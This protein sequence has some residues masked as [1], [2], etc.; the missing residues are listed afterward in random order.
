MS[1]FETADRD[2]EILLFE[3]VAD[4]AFSAMEQMMSNGKTSD[5]SH[6]AVQQILTAGIKLYARKI[7]EDS[8]YFMPIIKQHGVTATE[9]AIITTEL[10]FAVDLNLFDLSMWASRPRSDEE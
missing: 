9:A 2:E 7:D 10:L 5:L 3:K 8:S 6:L 1:P 4:E